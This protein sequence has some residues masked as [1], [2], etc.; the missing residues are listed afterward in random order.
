MMTESSFLGDI[1]FKNYLTTGNE[2]RALEK[3]DDGQRVNLKNRQIFK[4]LFLNLKIPV[5]SQRL[6]WGLGLNTLTQVNT[7]WSLTPWMCFIFARG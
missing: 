1:G 6:E 5:V 4:P 3:R 2:R 7:R